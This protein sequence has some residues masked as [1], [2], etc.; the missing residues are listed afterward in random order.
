MA[1]TVCAS[2]NSFVIVTARLVILLYTQCDV[3]SEAMGSRD[4]CNLE[5]EEV[6]LHLCMCRLAP[7]RSRACGTATLLPLYAT[8]TPTA[9]VVCV[10][11][12]DVEEGE[13]VR[14][15]GEGWG[16]GEGWGVR[17]SECEV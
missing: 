13:H 17:V 1:A 8:P 3:S 10:W 2:H 5:R 4:V 16:E 6:V 15:L 11:D 12:A 14:D 7:W 9:A